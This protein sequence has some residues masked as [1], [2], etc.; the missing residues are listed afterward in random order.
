MRLAASL[1]RP[2]A[3]RHAA[4]PRIA[5]RGCVPHA[6]PLFAFAHAPLCRQPRAIGPLQPAP[7]AA[8][9]LAGCCAPFCFENGCFGAAFALF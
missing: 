9:V 2:G 7:A 5:D 4:A 8:L 1:G 6:A 3:P